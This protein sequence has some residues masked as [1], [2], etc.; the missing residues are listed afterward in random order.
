M[1]RIA[2]DLT[3]VQFGNVDHLRFPPLHPPLTRLK[4]QLVELADFAMSRF[5]YVRSNDYHRAQAKAR[6][7]KIY[8]LLE[9]LEWL[10]QR[11]A[12]DV[13]RQTLVEV[14]AYWVLGGK[15]TR[16]ARNNAAFWS[17]VHDAKTKAVVNS[18]TAPVDMLDGWLD[19][20]SLVPF[21]FDV[22]LRG[23][24]L[25]VLNT[26][27][28]EQYRFHETGSQEV[29]VRQGDV[30]VDG[31]GCWG[32]TALYF[33]AKTGTQG[34][35]HVFEF[36]PSNLVVLRENL[37]RNPAL[38][39]QIHVHE[40]ALWNV[41][42]E[43]LHFGEAG[44]ST[45][46]SESSQGAMSAQTMSI[47]DWATSCGTT[48]VD[49]IKLDVEGAEKR[50]LEGA[51]QVIAKHKPTLAVALYHALEDFCVLPRLIDSMLPD[52]RFHLGHYTIHQEETILFATCR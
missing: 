48:S 33:A 39:P 50:C 29:A 41:S 31:G 43:T 21:G 23:H 34:A 19:D 47:D 46:L 6:L 22:R 30:V 11:L 5:G 42:G 15:H 32:D 2:N 20:F 27:L 49:F 45:A 10:H 14:I 13:S 38:S 26:F 24:K 8:P 12:D 52:H 7:E 3:R 37:E 28:L 40:R 36:S 18:K 16:L 9:G 17:A 25:N 4:L 51:R 1:Q 44:P 35:V